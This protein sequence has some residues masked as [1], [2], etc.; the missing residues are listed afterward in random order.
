ME[1]LDVQVLER[2]FGA[3]SDVLGRKDVGELVAGLAGPLAI[4]RRDL[5]G[6]YGAV[7]ANVVL[8]HLTD[9][10]LA[11]TVAVGE[12]GVEERDALV[13]GFAQ[14]F[15]TLAVVHATPHLTAE[16][17]AP[18]PDFTDLVARCAER[19]LFH[20]DLILGSRAA[21]AAPRPSKLPLLGSNQDSPDPERRLVCE[22]SSYITYT[23]CEFEFVEP[24]IT[25]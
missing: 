7:G 12:R 1:R 19:S 3:R 9:D 10:A 17:P 2:G 4:Q 13:D 21:S 25:S 6:N 16:S 8:Q 15:A 23:N 24:K 18:I 14:G 5:G 11:V 20:G 22:Q